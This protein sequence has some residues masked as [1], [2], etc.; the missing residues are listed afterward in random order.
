MKRRFDSDTEHAIAVAYQRG[1][2]ASSLAALYQCDTWTIYAVLRRCN[3]RR[4]SET[5]AQRLRAEYKP[6]TFHRKLSVQQELAILERYYH[7]ESTDEIARGV[8]VNVCRVAVIVR[9]A[10][11]TRSAHDRQVLRHRK[12]THPGTKQTRRRF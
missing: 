9:H 12:Y 7:G 11:L 4:R 10:G 6:A 2:G 1:D 5:E 8:P 3:I